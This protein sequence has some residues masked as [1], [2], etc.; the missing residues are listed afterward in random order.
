QG[1]LEIAGIVLEDPAKAQRVLDR[2][3]RSLER[4]KILS[5]RMLDYSGRGPS[6]SLPIDLGEL[7]TRHASLLSDL[8]GPGTELA[9]RI[10]EGLPPI[11]GD[12]EQLLQVLTALITN[13]H[14]ALDG[15]RGTITL[16]VEASPGANASEGNWVEP[17]PV[18]GA[19]AITVSD[20]GQGIAPEMVGRLFDPFFTTKETGRGLGLASALGILRNHHAGL[21]VRS[22]PGA[23]SRFRM[24]FPLREEKAQ[25]LAA[26]PAAQGPAQPRDAILLVDDDA[27]VRTTGQE[28]LADLLHY[29]VLTAK[30]GREALE[31]FR[32]HADE[33]ALI[34][35][36]AT[37]PDLS[38]GETFR[39]IQALRPDAKGILCSGYGDETG[40]KLVQDYG[41][42]GFL[43]KPYS[44]QDLKA[45]LEETF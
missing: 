9:Y 37:M 8:V 22:M 27:G 21:Q 15:C 34:L 7:V 10:T 36:D 33:V 16:V 11:E 38:G 39:A 42:Q 26:V 4:A 35:M 40:R 23:G 43:K 17:P 18:G 19:V 6:R 45:L 1:N 14:E 20:T 13:A 41:F 3:L 28:I 44:I 31:I 24:V 25:P 30:N 12:P 5:Q 2:A 29:R 32:G